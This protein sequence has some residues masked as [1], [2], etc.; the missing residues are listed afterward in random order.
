MNRRGFLKMLGAGAVVTAAGLMVPDVARRFFLPPRGGW[1][2]VDY[3]HGTD[4]TVVI[5][6]RGGG[7]S[8]GGTLNVG[9]IISFAPPMPPGHKHKLFVVTSTR[10]GTGAWHSKWR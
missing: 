4:K 5:E 7:G 9:D 2:G 3:A 1:T 8:G 10:S 6:L